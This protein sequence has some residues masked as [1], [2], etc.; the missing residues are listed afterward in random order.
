MWNDLVCDRCIFTNKESCLFLLYITNVVVVWVSLIN[1]EEESGRDVDNEL[2]FLSY[3]FYLQIFTYEK[4]WDIQ[5]HKAIE[6][7]T[8]IILRIFYYF[9][10]INWI[11]QI[12]S[13]DSAHVKH[14]MH[15]NMKINFSNHTFRGKPK[16]HLNYSEP[17]FQFFF[18]FAVI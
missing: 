6:R 12:D 3:I 9:F 10:L 4:K 18:Y 1:K 11:F 2:D 17:L 16:N 15:E 14:W 8:A 7:S 5:K 13:L